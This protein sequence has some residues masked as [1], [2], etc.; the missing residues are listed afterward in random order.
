[1]LEDIS[2]SY[3]AVGVETA[4]NN[5]SVGEY[6]EVVGEAVAEYSLTEIGALLVGPFKALTEFEMELIAYS[7]SA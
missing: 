3:Y 4:G 6:A 2:K 1:M 5:R 7:R